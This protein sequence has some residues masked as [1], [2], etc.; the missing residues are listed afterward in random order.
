MER[1]F[2]N[3]I[4]ELKPDVHSLLNHI[5][6]QLSP[7]IQ[8]KI[9]QANIIFTY[10]NEPAKIKTPKADLAT[11]RIYVQDTHMGFLWCCCYI[12]VSLN[13]LYYEMAVQ[14]TGDI[15]TFNSQD[16]FKK[17]MRTLDWAVSLKDEV[18]LWP[19]D[20][21]RP[22]QPDDWT[23][24]AT[25]LY[26]ACVAYLLFHEIG[27]VI[28]HQ[29]MLELAKARNDPFYE[30]SAEERASIFS[31]EVEADQFAL[32][33][34]MGTSTDEDVRFIKFVGGVVAHLSNFFTL[35][36]ADTRGGLHP[37]F[38][39]RLRAV[40]RQA[41]LKTEAGNI[42]FRAHLNIGLQLF[43][44]LTGVKFISDQADENIY[45]DFNDLENHLFGMLKDMK[46]SARNR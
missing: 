13:H 41:D 10:D 31:A 21:G 43:F 25:N 39:D 35:N 19:T 24:A 5:T 16:Q 1:Q 6:N 36:T 11:H 44:N 22:D 14:G 34:L 17:A 3:P 7:Q 46:D 29:D 37:D 12:T 18:T 30:L 20:I 33:C 9:A 8:E 23:A 45:K 42:H 26:Q 28:L 2:Y 4:E 15:V 32:D 27:H 38:D 40:I